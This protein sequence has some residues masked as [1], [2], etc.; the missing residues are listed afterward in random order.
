MP[1]AL[2]QRGCA[3][4]LEGTACAMMTSFVSCCCRFARIVTL[5]VI[6]L[7]CEG[8]LCSTG[9]AQKKN[10]RNR[11][12]HVALNHNETVCNLCHQSLHCFLGLAM[13]TTFLRKRSFRTIHT[14]LCSLP[15]QRRPWLAIRA[16]R[17]LSTHNDLRS[18][19]QH[20][21]VE[22]MQFPARSPCT[23]RNRPKS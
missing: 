14:S 21:T 18:G 19:F 4:Y 23:A 2:K 13:W 5:Q 12:R 17:L 8:A 16:S 20:L 9:M 22:H 1:E 7:C 3:G 15:N 11:P 6:K 10:L